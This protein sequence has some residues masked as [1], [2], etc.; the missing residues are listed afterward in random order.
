MVVVKEIDIYSLCEHHMYDK[1]RKILSLL[2]CPYI[3]SYAMCFRVPFFGKVSV[4]YLP[5]KRVLGLSKIARY[6]AYFYID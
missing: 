4:G 6:Y 1:K 3:K 5:N 2:I